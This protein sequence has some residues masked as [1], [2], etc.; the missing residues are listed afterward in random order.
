MNNSPFTVCNMVYRDDP[1]QLEMM[2]HQSAPPFFLF[3]NTSTK[4][5][6]RPFV[7]YSCI[8]MYDYLFCLRCCLSTIRR[9]QHPFD[10][11]I[12]QLHILNGGWTAHSFWD[13]RWTKFDK[14]LRPTKHRVNQFPNQIAHKQCDRT[15]RR[16]KKKC[17]FLSVFILLFHLR[18]VR[19]WSM[20]GERLCYFTS[21]EQ[22]QMCLTLLFIY[23]G[24][25]D[26]GGKWW[27]WLRLSRVCMERPMR[28][29]TDTSNM[30]NF[31][32]SGVWCFEGVIGRQYFIHFVL[33]KFSIYFYDGL[34]L[35]LIGYWYCILL[36]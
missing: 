14:P 15:N 34:L 9:F 5:T 33:W 29:V 2:S 27:S 12:T 11:Q 19:I 1:L 30:M 13:D 6:R 10:V 35:G 26:G 16:Y 3:T 23:V 25:S 22:L 20:R 18:D 21:P 24:A 28:A 36:I 8:V 4:N 7:L 32:F 17:T 31:R